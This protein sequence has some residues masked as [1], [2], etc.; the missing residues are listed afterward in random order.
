MVREDRNGLPDT[1]PGLSTLK[2][3]VKQ[4]HNYNMTATTLIV[5]QWNKMLMFPAARYPRLTS[6]F[7]CVIISDIKRSFVFFIYQPGEM[8]WVKDP[9]IRIVN[10]VLTGL[11]NQN[12]L[13]HVRR[14]VYTPDRSSN[15]GINGM[16][17]YE[18][19]Y[20]NSSEHK[21]LRWM[22]RQTVP[23]VIP[24]TRPCAPSM[25]FLRSDMI[26][27]T[28]RDRSLGLPTT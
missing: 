8:K 22:E 3:M 7:Q 11:G 28:S 25:R 12:G 4:K 10:N 17:L 26:E 16:Y 19:S 1:M 6:T 13:E 18:Y 2:T 21:C 23:D 5:V 20:A 9:T 15:I 27:I 24:Q 14:G